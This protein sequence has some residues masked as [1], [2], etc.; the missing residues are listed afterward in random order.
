MSQQAVAESRSNAAVALIEKSIPEYS[1]H[2]L[3][4]TTTV[5]DLLLDLRTMLIEAALDD[6]E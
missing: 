2:K 5:V 6:A 3:A 4:D 1:N